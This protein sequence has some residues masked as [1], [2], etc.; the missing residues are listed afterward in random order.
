MLL[1]KD[2]EYEALPAEE[3]QELDEL[4]TSITQ[5]KRKRIQAVFA[6]V[7][8]AISS[9][10]YFGFASTWNA[11][12]SVRELPVEKETVPNRESFLEHTARETARETG[13]RYL[14]GTRRADIT[15]Y[16]HAESISPI[17]YSKIL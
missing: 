7:V 4:H 12:P 9:L 8:I 11:S 2:Q 3:K 13:D 6:L 14:L 15:G 5:T 16:V 10:A 17:E 1:F